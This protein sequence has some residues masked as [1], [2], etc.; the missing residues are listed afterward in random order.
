[1]KAKNN[2]QTITLAIAMCAAMSSTASAQIH[3]PIVNQL[4]VLSDL[5][6]GVIG[7]LPVLSEVDQQ[8]GLSGLLGFRFLA[9]PDTLLGLES[10][11][12]LEGLPLLG[13]LPGLD[14][15]P[16]LDVITGALPIR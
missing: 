3:L 12:L 15:V 6:V 14:G 16:G 2:T 9:N 8:L 7:K 13:E 10:L 4:P 5:S 11:P 1:M